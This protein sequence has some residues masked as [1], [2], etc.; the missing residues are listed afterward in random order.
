V[1]RVL[2]DG[3]ADRAGVREGDIIVRFDDQ[4]IDFSS[5]LPHVVGR[6]KV[7]S[8]ATMQVVREGKEISLKVRVGELPDRSEEVASIDAAGE[9]AGS[10]P[11]RIGVTVEGLSGEVRERAGIEGGVQVVGVEG[12]AAEAGLREGDIITALNNRQVKDVDSFVEI[13]E[14]LPAGRSVPVLIIRGREPSY[15]PLRVP[16]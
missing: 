10:T 15:L 16:E 3:P 14:S 7:G 4:P 13:A 6:T 2:E 11:S 5:E 1:T 8:D 9:P 12:A